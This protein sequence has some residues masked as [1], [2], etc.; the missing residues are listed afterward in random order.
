V[1]A[2]FSQTNEIIYAVNS[3]GALGC[4]AHLDLVAPR[5]GVPDLVRHRSERPQLGV[6]SVTAAAG[7]VSLP[8]SY[9]QA[10]P[11]RLYPGL[12]QIDALLP[13][14]PGGAGDVTVQLTVERH[15]PPTPATSPSSSAARRRGRE[16][17]R[18]GADPWSA[19][20]PLAG[21]SKM[22][23]RIGPSP[24]DVALDTEAAGLGQYDIRK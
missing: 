23:N 11:E 22:R 14:K 10:R 12:D 20:G 13:A 16:L 21:F 1:K 8:V 4:G 6:D 19:A 9:A 5:P 24:P 18:G 17:H 15:T 7:G 3:S 2:D